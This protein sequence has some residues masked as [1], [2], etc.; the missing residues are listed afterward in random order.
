[1]IALQFVPAE[2][3]CGGGHVTDGG[4]FVTMTRKL[5]RSVRPKPS[6]AS[7]PTELV[8][9]GNTLPEGGW[10]TMVTGA[11][12]PALAVGVKFTKD[13]I[14]LW[15]SVMMSSGHLISGGVWVRMTR[16]WHRSMLP[17]GSETTQFTRLV[18]MGNVL[19]DG[20]RQV[21]VMVVL[22]LVLAS[23]AKLTSAPFSP[24]QPVT[25]S[26]GQVI[27][28]HSAARVVL[29]ATRDRTAPV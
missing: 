29:V 13:P 14:G 17:R 2:M 1:M 25:M 7:Q 4:P 11:L 15:H 9:M 16:E 10:Q 22:Q 18:P 19:P 8:P 3:V 28:T 23:G 5:H 21:T 20:G 26:L 12:Q 24:W 6:L 27:E